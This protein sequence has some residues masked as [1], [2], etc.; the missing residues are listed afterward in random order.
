M[1]RALPNLL[2]LILTN[3]NLNLNLRRVNKITMTAID[4]KSLTTVIAALL[5][6]QSTVCDGS[7]P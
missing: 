1:S 4:M 7:P 2:I 3:L 5:L 6:I